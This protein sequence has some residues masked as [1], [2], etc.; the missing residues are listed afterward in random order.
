MRPRRTGGLLTAVLLTTA[1]SALP[2]EG[3]DG[4][5]FRFSFGW[6]DMGGD[7]AEVLDG[8]VD[9]EFSILYPVGALRLGAGANWVS[10]EMDDVEESWNQIQAHFLVALPLQ[11]SPGLRVYGEGR[12][13]YRRL[14]PEEDRYFG[15][16]EALLGDFVASGNGFEAVL[17]S[18]I[19]LGPLWA[20]DLSAAF[21]RFTTT[22]DLSEQALGTVDSGSTWRVH[23]GLTWFPAN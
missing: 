6:Q 16:E 3:Q 7:M 21:G 12:Y 8:H 4:I 19:V 5:G 9:S 22:P 15:G 13:T 23:A 17:G 18:E 1:L 20:I 10:F 14:R 11:V 2:A